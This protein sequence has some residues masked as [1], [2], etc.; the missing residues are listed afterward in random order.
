MV[1]WDDTKRVKG[2]EWGVGKYLLLKLM[3][4]YDKCKARRIIAEK[5]VNEA[6]KG[7][8]ENLAFQWEI[9]LV[10]TWQ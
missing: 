6:K 9:M 8:C 5:A 4:D 2:K 1:D 3:I 7:S 10:K